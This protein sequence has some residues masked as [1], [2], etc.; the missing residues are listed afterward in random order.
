MKSNRFTK[1]KREISSNK[2]EETTIGTIN[3]IVQK[4]TDKNN[5]LD[6]ERGTKKCTSLTSLFPNI[7]C[8]PPSHT[9][10]TLPHKPK[11]L[12]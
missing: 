6:T 2:R 4:R 3:K 8:S 10:S 5:Q 1:I 11:A 9:N 7:L 12:G